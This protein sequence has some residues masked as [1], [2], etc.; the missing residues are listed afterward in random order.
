M[1]RRINIEYIH[2]WNLYIQGV[3]FGLCSTEDAQNGCIEMSFKE[4]I[5]NQKIDRN[6]QLV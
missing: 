6:N 2:G 5:N 3:I 1:N 4:L